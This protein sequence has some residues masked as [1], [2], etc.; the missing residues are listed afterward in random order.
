MQTEATAIAPKG[1][2]VAI[3]ARR[4]AAGIARVTR[5]WRERIDAAPPAFHSRMGA[6][7]MVSPAAQAARQAMQRRAEEMQADRSSD[8]E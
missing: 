6:F 2:V 7:E 4:L 5:G 1:N 8:R 3:V